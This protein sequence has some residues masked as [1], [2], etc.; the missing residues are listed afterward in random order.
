MEHPAIVQVRGLRQQIGPVAALNS[1]AFDVF[2]GEIFGLIGTN[3]AGKTTTMKALA[4]V[5]APTAGTVKVLGQPPAA[6]RPSIGYLTQ[7]FSLY[8]DLSI[9]EN[10]RYY[11]RMRRLPEQTLQTRRQQYLEWLG[12]APFAERLAGQLSGG[13]RQK[14]ALCCALITNPPVLLLDE[15]STGI[16]AVFRREIWAFLAKIAQQGTTIVVAT[17]YLDEAERCDRVALIHQGTIHQIGPPAQLRQSLDLCCLEI[18]PN[19]SLLAS[20]PVFTATEQALRDAIACGNTPITDLQTLGDRLL[21]FGRHPTATATAVHQV[22]RSHGLSEATL[23]PASLTLEHVMAY[24]LQQRSANK[25]AP[26]A[27]GIP[28]ISPLRFPYLPLRTGTAQS[29]SSPHLTPNTQHP[30]PDTRYPIPPTLTLPTHPPIH[31]PP[32][33]LLKVD[34]ASKTYGSF[35]AVQPLNI[36]IRRGEICGLLGANG[37]GKTTLMKMLCGLLP[38]TSGCISV[39]DA[40]LPPTH[41]QVKRRIGYMS[42]KFALYPDLT[43]HENL[44]FFGRAYRVPRRLRAERIAWVLDILGLAH[45]AHQ[46]VGHLS[47]G[48]QQ[49]VAFGAAILHQPEILFLDEPTAGMDLL[50][51]RQFWQLLQQFA[52]QGTAIVVTTHSMEEAEYCTQLFLMRSGKLIVEGSPTAIKAQQGATLVEITSASPPVTLY[53]LEQQFEP[54]RLVFMGDRIHMILDQPHHQSDL[55]DYLNTVESAPFQVVAIPFSLEAA[56]LNIAQRPQRR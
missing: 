15:V 31:S 3:G 56:F 40:H 39:T 49:R 2:P 13:M 14:L 1:I 23:H 7:T 53:A 48:N 6:V 10:L 47:G 5:Y 45:Q 16:D 44:T 24:R 11:A 36:A 22:L 29:P 30:I 41:P 18:I 9:H 33:C 55:Q 27:P 21:I 32:L 50:V 28:P 38:P 42:Q 26:K 46:R 52:R 12:L 17:H 34:Q 35:E 20:G 8:A 37:A 51:R 54:W 4:G 43:I 19:D 25:P